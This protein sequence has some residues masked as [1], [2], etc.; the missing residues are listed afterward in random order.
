VPAATLAY[1]NKTKKQEKKK[2]ERER[3]REKEEKRKNE[4]GEVLVGFSL[5][6]LVLLY[7]L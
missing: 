1:S 3:K 5:F 4:L 6:L 7:N 2:G